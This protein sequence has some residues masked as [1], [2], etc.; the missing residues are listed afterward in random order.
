M[1]LFSVEGPGKDVIDPG[2]AGQV[3]SSKPNGIQVNTKNTVNVELK[4]YTLNDLEALKKK[5]KK[6]DLNP[7]I[8]MTEEYKNGG[9][10]NI[11]MKT[12]LFEYMKEMWIADIKK[13][14]DIKEVTPIT[15]A[16]AETGMNG[17]ADVEYTFE[18]TYDSKGEENKVKVKCYLTKCRI[19]IQHMGGPSRAKDCLDGKHSPKYFG[20]KF[21][22]P[23]AEK[24]LKDNPNL[25]DIVLPIPRTE[26]LRLEENSRTLKKG[27]KAKGGGQASCAAR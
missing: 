22:V 18:V 5:M 7:G 2:E 15:K 24:V 19:Q 1:T 21:M 23:W 16:Q 27:A 9:N 6:A 14:D 20:D 4:K 26:I 17:K 8:A 12:S 13:I 25:D 11:D 3:C 10:V